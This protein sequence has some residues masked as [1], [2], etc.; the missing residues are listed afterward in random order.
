MR[1][2]ILCAL[3]AL[4]LTDVIPAEEKPTQTG[5][6]KQRFAV[7]IREPGGVSGAACGGCCEGARSPQQLGGSR[8]GFDGEDT[9]VRRNTTRHGEGQS[10]DV[11]TDIDGKIVRLQQRLHDRRRARF[12]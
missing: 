4:V 10:T 1:V 7:S 9:S 8:R 6:W 12:K 3:T 11:S 5:T 2:R